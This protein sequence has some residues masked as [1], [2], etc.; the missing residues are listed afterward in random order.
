MKI[1]KSL[2]EGIS[3]YFYEKS[4]A[5]PRQQTDGEVTARTT[6]VKVDKANPVFDKFIHILH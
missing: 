1:G 2:L 6:K 4:I 3:V 5:S